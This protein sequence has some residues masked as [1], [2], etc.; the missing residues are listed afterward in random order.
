MNTESESPAENAQSVDIEIV[1]HAL[2]DPTRRR[3]LDRLV[4]R[5][6][7]G[8]HLAESFGITLTAVMQH[9]KILENARLVQTEKVGRVRSCRLDL[10]GFRALEQWSSNHRSPWERKLDQLAAMLAEDE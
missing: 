10:A 2:G 5:P 9:V 4:E 3:I 8:S 1:F 7:S 6:L